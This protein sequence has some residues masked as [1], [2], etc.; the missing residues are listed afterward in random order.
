MSGLHPSHMA[1]IDK[2]TSPIIRHARTDDIP[3]VLAIYAPFVLHSTTSFELEVPSLAAFTTRIQTVQQLAPWLVC[4]LEGQIAGYAYAGPHRSRAGYRFNRELSVYVAEGFRRRG[5]ATALYTTLIELLKLQGFTNT[6]IGITLPNDASVRF[7]EKM[8]YRPIGIYHGI[9][10]K[11]GQFLDVGW[12][13]MKI[14]DVWRDMPL[15]PDQI[16]PE[17]Y[18]RAIAAGLKKIREPGKNEIY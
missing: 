10:Y 1:Y 12:W 9:G 6:L 15:T 11:N 16:E 17:D 13:E 2:P 18:D 7:H 5:V 8:G 4:E 14:Q 3:A